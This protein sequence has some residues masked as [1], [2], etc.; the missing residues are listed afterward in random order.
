[1]LHMC[2]LFPVQ[3]M[4]CDMDICY[5]SS[6][7]VGI[8]RS[9]DHKGPNDAGP[10]VWWPA[11]VWLT[12]HGCADYT[13]VVTLPKVLFFSPGEKFLYHLCFKTAKWQSAC[14]FTLSDQ[15]PSLRFQ[16]FRN[17]RVTLKSYI[18]MFSQSN[19]FLSIYAS[20]LFF[21]VLYVVLSFD[22]CGRYLK[23]I[24]KLVL[25]HAH[26]RSPVFHYVMFHY[27]WG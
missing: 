20:W 19:L 21:K 17:K 22:L 23:A 4:W 5:L 1:M 12:F 7:S 13:K 3:C 6:H 27:L 25:S 26:N 14:H 9:G 18:N 10:R 16:N 15:T 2:S 8:Y 11:S 24:K